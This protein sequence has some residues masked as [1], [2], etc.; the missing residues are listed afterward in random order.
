MIVLVDPT[1][2]PARMRQRYGDDVAPSHS[3]WCS[4]P[5]TASSG[6]REKAVDREPADGDEET[7][8]HE[9]ELVVQP[10]GAVCALSGRGHAV[11]SAAGLRAR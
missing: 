4:R 2:R 7:R 1:A 11:A 6:R 8:P 5:T 9:P 10:V 3:I